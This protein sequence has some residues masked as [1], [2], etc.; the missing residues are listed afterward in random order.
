[1][2]FQEIWLIIGEYFFSI[3]IIGISLLCAKVLNTLLKRLIERTETREDLK[4][5]HQI[6]HKLHP[7]YWIVFFVGVYFALRII[8]FLADYVTWVD[9]IFF[10]I[11]VILVCYALAHILEILIMQ[12][13]RERKDQ[14]EVKVPGIFLKVINAII[15]LIGLLVI[16]GTYQVDITPLLTTLGISGIAIGFA[17]QNTLSNLFAGLHIMTDRP[18]SVGDYIELD[19]VNA[20]GYV[21]DIRWAS[22]RLRTSS[23]EIIVIPNSRLAQAVIKNYH[24]IRPKKISIK[25]AVGYGYDLQLVEEISRDVARQVQSKIPG[26]SKIKDPVIYFQSFGESSIEFEVN[27]YVEKYDIQFLLKHEFI[28]ALKKRFE[29]EGIIMPPT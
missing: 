12:W 1:M 14:E 21:E 23:D 25:S 9:S 4:N 28:K 26:G 29:V 11:I 7:L 20:G 15:Y 8:P 3:L 22:T 18:I 2:V 13:L 27:M 17:L 5:T 16:L 24:T 19:G 10:V 6:L